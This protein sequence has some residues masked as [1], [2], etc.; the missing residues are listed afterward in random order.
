MSISKFKTLLVASVIGCSGFAGQAYAQ[1]AVDDRDAGVFLERIEE[2]TKKEHE[3]AD[4]FRKD[5]TTD[6]YKSQIEHYDRE[7]E[8]LNALI[9]S[10]GYYSVEGDELK[11]KKGSDT[12]FENLNTSTDSRTAVQNA[13]EGKSK[14]FG[15]MLDGFDSTFVEKIPVLGG[16]VSGSGPVAFRKEFGLTAPDVIY[17]GNEQSQKSLSRKYSSLYFA[18]TV[19][20]ESNVGRKERLKVYDDLITR[21]KEAGD[22][23]EAIRVQNAILLENGRNL[24]LLIDLQTAQLNSQTVNM[25]DST[26]DANAP[27]YMFGTG[28]RSILGDRAF[29]ELIKAIN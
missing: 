22:I 9:T 13:A 6:H 11:E 17:A 15:I 18:N 27:A 24:A 19:A 28:S 21:A 3:A 29:A 7:I 8:R 20:G 10:L 16:L 2:N 1:I 5:N 14:E 23:Q 12:A 4:K 25:M 26:A